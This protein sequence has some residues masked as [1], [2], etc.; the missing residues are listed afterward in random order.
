MLAGLELGDRLLSANATPV[1]GGRPGALHEVVKA[2][3][4]VAPLREPREPRAARL[5]PAAEAFTAYCDKYPLAM[6]DRAFQA[7]HDELM[8]RAA[9][10][11]APA[12]AGY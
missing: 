8:G 2:R 11:A 1:S 3:D 10:R 7:R 4:E 9:P 5:Q 12:C 6:L